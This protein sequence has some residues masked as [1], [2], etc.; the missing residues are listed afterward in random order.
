MKRNKNVVVCTKCVG[1]GG[2]RVLTTTI[3]LIATAAAAAARVRRRERYSARPVDTGAGGHRTTGSRFGCRRLGGPR[4]AHRARRATFRWTG[5]GAVAA[6][7]TST[8]TT[9]VGRSSHRR[10]PSELSARSRVYHV[11]WVGGDGEMGARCNGRAHILITRR[12]RGAGRRRV[13]LRGGVVGDV[14]QCVGAGERGQ[15]TPGPPSPPPLPHHTRRMKPLS[16]CPSRPPP[17][18]KPAPATSTAAAAK[19]TAM[20]TTATA[21]GTT[22]GRPMAARKRYGPPVRPGDFFAVSLE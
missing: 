13:V 12:S 11:W 10:R 6:T 16:R 14:K 15:R 17:P 20:T 7:T 18:H 4:P 3:A 5:G 2:A 21:T 22:T 8:T 9:T 19:S 1:G